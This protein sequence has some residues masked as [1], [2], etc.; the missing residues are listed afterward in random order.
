M[1][2]VPAVIY[3]QL[4]QQ[5]APLQLGGVLVGDAEIPPSKDLVAKALEPINVLNQVTF[6]SR[7]RP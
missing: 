5:T 3:P 1:L 7:S 6:E 2:L 4:V